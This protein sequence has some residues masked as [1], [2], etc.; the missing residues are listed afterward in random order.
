MATVSGYTATRM[1]VTEDASIVDGE[2]DDGDLILKRKDG[3]WLNA[4]AVR[5]DVGVDG[6]PGGI[7]EAPTDGGDYFRK[8]ETWVQ[9]PLVP[10]APVDGKLY[11]RRDADWSILDRPWI[12]E[13]NELTTPLPAGF[14]KTDI[15]PVY[16]WTARFS[17]TEYLVVYTLDFTIKGDAVAS[18]SHFVLPSNMRPLVPSMTTAYVTSYD[19][20]IAELYGVVNMRI[21]TNGNVA[22]NTSLS[23]KILMKSLP[24]SL[25]GDG[26]VEEFTTSGEVYRVIMSGVYRRASKALPNLA[27]Y[28]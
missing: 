17:G 27:T 1:K 10:E 20:P 15:S 12:L 22:A 14:S 16:E 6:P 8:N 7:P 24:A 5:G 26:I 21:N 13:L 11:L 18:I 9:L 3:T 25:A 19:D 28:I 4:G 23:S 2:I